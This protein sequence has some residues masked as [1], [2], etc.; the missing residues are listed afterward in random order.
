[1]KGTEP[2][3]SGKYYKHIETGKYLCA[4]CQAELFVS[5]TKFDSGTGWPSFFSAIP[6]QVSRTEDR[7]GGMSRTEINCAQCQSHLGH[8]FSDGPAPT[9]ERFCVNSL[10]LDFKPTDTDPII[11]ARAQLLRSEIE[12]YRFAYHVENRSLI[13]EAVLDQLKHELYQLEQA[14]PA[15]IHATSPTQRVGGLPLPQFLKI[16]HPSPLLSMEDVFSFQELQDWETRLINRRP[17]QDWSYSAMY[18]IDGLAVSLIYKNGILHSA[19]TRGD[20]LVGEDVTQNIRTIESIPLTLNWPDSLGPVPSQLEVRGEIYI[21]TDAFQ[22]LNQ[23]QITAGL[24]PFANPRNL[25]AGSIRQLD[26]KI[27]ASRPLSFMAWEL[28]Y[29]P[30]QSDQSHSL[31]LLPQLG[32]KT[33]PHHGPSIL[34][35]IAQ[36][37]ATAQTA[38]PTLDYWIDGLVIKV[39]QLEIYQNFGVVGKTPR[40]LVAWKFP[41]EEA[42]ATLLSVNWQVGRTGTITPVAV[43]TPTSIAGTTVQ[44]ATLHNLDEIARL[45]LKIGDRVILIKAGDIIP[46][47][48]SVLDKLRTGNETAIAIPTHCPICG[49]EVVRLMDQVAL[50]CPSENC[51]AKECAAVLHAARAFGV[52]GLGEKV[53]E[54]LVQSGL[55]LT[56]P[57]LWQLKSADLETISGFAPVS[58]KKLFNE[59]QSKRSIRWSQFILALNIPHV[60]DETAHLLAT[61]FPSLSVLQSATFDRLLAIP[62]IGPIISKTV[63]DFFSSTSGQQLL[64]HWSELNLTIQFPSPTPSTISPTTS[65]AT[66]LVGKTFVLTGT[67]ATIDRAQAKTKIRDLGGT[68]SESVS[69]KTSYLV[70]G[71]NPGS[72][73]AIAESLGVSLLLEPE[74]LAMIS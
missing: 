59:L 29:Q 63:S 70:V 50:R 66:S 69:K 53:V 40:A 6:N 58:A 71:E 4:N 46:K 61:N 41:A 57:D 52:D 28:N 74:F 32:F 24:P 11:Q 17:A 37:Y 18:K 8:V 13:P 30:D 16:T 62:A 68:I 44:H 5:G 1:M 67:L 14:H 42:V 9:G 43:L 31:K 38:R 15:L 33:V 55:V 56:P 3:F 20:G 73:V 21:K 54:K 34:G 25:A 35:Q 64:A 47:I 2:P 36:W 48:S 65:P 23:A 10:A 72:K 22:K 49:G 60:G 26:P 51:F 27:A 19:A 39:D 7:S 12:R 45:G